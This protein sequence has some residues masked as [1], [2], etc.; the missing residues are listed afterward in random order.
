MF[1][2]SVSSSTGFLGYCTKQSYG[3]RL[4]FP[5]K[6]LPSLL[7]LKWG[8][9]CVDGL[10]Q[11]A[12]AAARFIALLIISES[13]TSYIASSFSGILAICWNSLEPHQDGRQPCKE[14]PVSS[15]LSRMINHKRHWAFFEFACECRMVCIGQ[16]DH[17]FEAKV[18]ENNHSTQLYHL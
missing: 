11:V 18:R 3:P 17:S 7:G 5:S 10:E 13:H 9:R 14:N 12:T 2:G 16:T 15:G 8:G 4:T 1:S 6:M